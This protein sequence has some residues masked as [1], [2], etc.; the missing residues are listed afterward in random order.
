MVFFRCVYEF[1]IIG[2]CLHVLYLPVGVYAYMQHLNV[3]YIFLWGILCLGSFLYDIIK[4]I[5]PSFA[6][7]FTITLVN[8][9]VLGLIPIASASGVI[10]SI[11]V[12]KDYQKKRSE[13]PWEAGK[14]Y[15]TVKNTLPFD[16]NASLQQY[17][18]THFN[19]SKYVQKA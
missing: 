14:T 7:I 4:I 1:D 18:S 15:G 2:V 11:A 19:S 10:F 17:M 6:D 9:L 5:F 13:L 12:V 16:T 3:T 8:A